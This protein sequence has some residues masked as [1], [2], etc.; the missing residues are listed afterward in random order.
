[1]PTLLDKIAKIFDFAVKNEDNIDKVLQYLAKYG[2]IDATKESDIEQLIK[3]VISITKAAGFSSDGTISNETLKIMQL[4]RCGCKDVGFLGQDATALAKWG[5]NDLTYCIVS[6]PGSIG[7]EDWGNSLRIAF[8]TGEAIANVKF[9]QVDKPNNADFVIGAGDGQQDQFDGPGGVL[10]WCELPPIPNFIG[11]LNSKFDARELWVPD[12]QIKNG[13][14]VK[15][16]AAH[17]IV[18]HGLGLPHTDVPGS[19]MNPFYNPDIDKPQAHD[20]SELVARYGK[21]LNTPQPQ[22]Q[23]KPPVTPTGDITLTITG[24]ISDI[25]APGFRIYRE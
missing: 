16:V 21:P 25:Q 24:K 12:G 19:L 1:M 3:A 7:K 22:P 2:Y 6:R 10:A 11:Q 8:N 14:K 20:I 9:T 5:K 23:P 17:E 4:P 13:I 15:N 18:G